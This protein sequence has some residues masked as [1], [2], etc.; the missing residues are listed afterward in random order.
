MQEHTNTNNLHKPFSDLHVSVSLVSNHVYVH[1]CRCM[2]RSEG[3]LVSTLTL[4][5]L[6]DS[7]LCSL[8]SHILICDILLSLCLTLL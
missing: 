3:T 1:E 6:L 2:Q 8:L 4:H 7:V 5:L